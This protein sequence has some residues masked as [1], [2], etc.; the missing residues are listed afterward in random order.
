[1]KKLIVFALVLAMLFLCALPSFALDVNESEKRVFENEDT[2]LPYRLILPE[3]YDDSSTY[4]LLVF[5]H[6]VGER[7]NDNELQLKLC[8][9]YIADSLP[10]CIIVVPQCP[11]DG[12]WVDFPYGSG[13]YSIEAIPESNELIALMQLL[14]SLKEELSIDVDRIYA[15]GL[16]MGGFGAWDLMMRHNDYFA[17][18]ILVCGGGDPSQAEV[19]KDTPLF[20]FHG[21]A[22][23]VVPVAGSR[24]TVQ[25][26]KDAGGTLV[27]YV[28][29]EKGSHFIWD[30]AFA[31]EGMLSQLLT[32]KLS[33]RYPDM[34]KDDTKNIGVP[35]LIAAA[36]VVL[37][38]F[39][40]V[41]RKSRK[42]G[43]R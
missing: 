6:G 25:A 42:G 23:T 27:T 35:I 36:V 4:P 19:L 13:T 20:V 30:T 10:E 32:Y 9:Q 2:V 16:S 38:V 1:M 17:A 15:S 7:G 5:L 24:D 14:D 43:K 18:G 39:V 8:V 40:V 41:L 33:D 26:I 21:S 31:H 22:D 3:N 28:E 11:L 34:F 29:Y 12:M 37:A